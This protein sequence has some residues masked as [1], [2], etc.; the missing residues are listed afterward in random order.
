MSG[1]DLVKSRRQNGG[2]EGTLGSQENANIPYRPLPKFLGWSKT[3]VSVC[4]LPLDSYVC[5]SCVV[6]IIR[7]T[8]QGNQHIS[9][10]LSAM[11]TENTIMYEKVDW[12]EFQKECCCEG[13]PVQESLLEL[14]RRI[15]LPWPKQRDV[16]L[17]EGW[18]CPRPLT[19]YSFQSFCQRGEILGKLV[20]IRVTDDEGGQWEPFAWK[21]LGR[22]GSSGSLWH[23]RGRRQWTDFHVLSSTALDSSIVSVLPLSPTSR[24]SSLSSLHCS[25][26]LLFHW[27]TH[28]F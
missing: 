13:K 9:S 16:C 17:R 23:P 8:E 25:C 27:R 6:A 22:P 5:P 10:Y 11:S 14:S 24:A 7:R 1:T 19:P 15:K 12:T 21:R 20:W 26:G 18:N 2:I 3:T 4:D 28:C